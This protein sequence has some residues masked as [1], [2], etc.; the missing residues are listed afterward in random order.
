MDND[1]LQD[2]T[3][4]SAGGAGIDLATIDI[5]LFNRLL[6]TG[7]IRSNPGIKTDYAKKI[8]TLD[9]KHSSNYCNGLI[10]AE[11]L[12]VLKQVLR[13]V[14]QDFSINHNLILELKPQGSA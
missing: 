6:K 9:E 1:L 5:D 12:L 3:N 8:V 10:L 13:R 2:Q 7:I 4:A 14:N 11:Y